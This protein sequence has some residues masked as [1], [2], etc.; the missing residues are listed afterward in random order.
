[1][2]YDSRGRAADVADIARML[3]GS[4]VEGSGGGGG[5]GGYGRARRERE[6]ETQA[7]QEIHR[8][9]RKWRQRERTIEEERRREIIGKQSTKGER[10]TPE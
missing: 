5:C 7:L 10:R 2:L 3:V 6:N 1:M 4:D 8:C 9:K